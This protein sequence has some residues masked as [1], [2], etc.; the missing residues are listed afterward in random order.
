[1]KELHELDYGFDNFIKQLKPEFEQARHNFRVAAFRYFRFLDFRRTRRHN[2]PDHWEES[3]KTLVLAVFAVGIFGQQS[4]TKIAQSTTTLHDPLLEVASLPITSDQ[5]VSVE[6][7]VR[8]SGMENSFTLSTYDGSA[9]EIRST[10][11]S[12]RVL[13][14]ATIRVVLGGVEING[15]IYPSNSSI[16]ARRA[17]QDDTDSNLKSMQEN[18][19]KLKAKTPPPKDPNKPNNNNNQGNTPTHWRLLFSENPMATAELFNAAAIQ[20]LVHLSPIG[21]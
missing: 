4:N 16:V 3:V 14:P 6:P 5:N 19:K 11:G 10:K 1:V 15:V 2:S 9:L 18:A 12:F 8:I 20:Q 17:V 21:F 13:S 7:G